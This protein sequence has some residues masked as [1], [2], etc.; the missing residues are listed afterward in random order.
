LAANVLHD[1]ISSCAR[2]ACGWTRA[3]AE[4]I[5]DDRLDQELLDVLGQFEVECLVA[6]VVGA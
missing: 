3:P 5:I 4:Q 2:F 1:P 6:T